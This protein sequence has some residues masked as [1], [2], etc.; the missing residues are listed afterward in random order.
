M[1]YFQFTGREVITLVLSVIRGHSEDSVVPLLA[2]SVH[3]QPEVFFMKNES[4]KEHKTEEVVA[5]K[6]WWLW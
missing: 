4:N 2:D 1:L 5:W 3:G 6:N